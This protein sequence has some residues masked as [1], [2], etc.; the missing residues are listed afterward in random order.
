MLILYL[1]FVN[2]VCIFGKFLHVDRGKLFGGP[3]PPMPPCAA[4]PDKVYNLY[5]TYYVGKSLG[6]WTILYYTKS[7]LECTTF[8]WIKIPS[9]QYDQQ[10]L[11]GIFPCY[12]YMQSKNKVLKLSCKQTRL[13]IPGICEKRSIV[14]FAQILEFPFKI[15]LFCL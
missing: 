11:K 10:A 4:R 5:W 15:W 12:K 7:V 14:F 9:I 6:I 8:K 3:W 13:F 1:L 2:Y